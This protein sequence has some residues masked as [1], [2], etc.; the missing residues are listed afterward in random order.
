M[1][2]GQPVQRNLPFTQQ[3]A[4]EAQAREQ[5]QSTR[6][7]QPAQTGAIPAPASAG[8]NS[9]GVEALNSFAAK[10]KA[11]QFAPGASLP[12]TAPADIL[13]AGG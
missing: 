12:G 6:T 3:A 5:L 11:A 9:P 8:Q 7:A 10:Q 2:T 1:P 4:Q 13:K